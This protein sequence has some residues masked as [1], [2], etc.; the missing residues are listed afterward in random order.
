V[1]GSHQE[2][3]A[4]NRSVSIGG[5]GGGLLGILGSIVSAGGSFMQKHAG[6]TGSE[7]VMS[8]ASAVAQVGQAAEG[9]SMAANSAFSQAA[10]HVKAGGTEQAAKGSIVGDLLSSLLPGS[11][12]FSTVVEKFRSD[13]VGLARTEQ[14]GLYKNTVVGHTQTTSVGKK[15]KELI[16]EDYD[17]EAKKS[18][19]S[20]T[21]KHTL[22]AKERVVIGGPGGTIIIDS[23]GVTIKARHIWLKSPAVDIQTGSPDGATLTSEKPFV[24]D[25]SKG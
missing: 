22:M 11:G 14:I 16:G 20:R 13:T 3:I 10:N 25:C 7:S 8:F 17:V 4:G 1:G 18:I 15:K 5:N 2:R 19:F 21:T 23:S 24:E 9:M 6:Q 12:L